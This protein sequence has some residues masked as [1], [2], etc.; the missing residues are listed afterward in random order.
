MHQQKKHQK[1]YAPV[2]KTKNASGGE[3]C[4]VS[5]ERAVAILGFPIILRIRVPEH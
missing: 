2:S 3:G 5:R 1:K 4:S